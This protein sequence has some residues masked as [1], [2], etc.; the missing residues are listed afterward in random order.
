MALGRSSFAGELSGLNLGSGIFKANDFISY[1]QSD[2]A[3]KGWILSSG[4]G[5][6]ERCTRG[7]ILIPFIN[8][9]ELKFDIF[10]SIWILKVFILSF[11]FVVSICFF[12]VLSL[13]H[14]FSDQTGT[15]A[16]DQNR[17]F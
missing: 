2:A 8:G 12:F 14:T 13:L 11:L 9:C 1:L 5:A 7:F 16:S 3:L 6:W 15:D 4:S 17:N 10:R